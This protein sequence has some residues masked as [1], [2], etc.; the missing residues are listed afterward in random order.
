[1]YNVQS[2]FAISKCNMSPYLESQ[3]INVSASVREIWSSNPRPSKSYA[4]L[5]TA[6]HH[7]NIYAS[8]IVHVLPWRYVTDGHRQLVYTLRR[9]TASIIKGLVLYSFYIGKMTC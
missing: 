2:S 4:A 1:V 7:F 5:Q 6:R 9:N 3:T 8:T